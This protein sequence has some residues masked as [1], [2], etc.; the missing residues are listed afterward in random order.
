MSIKRVSAILAILAWVHV[1]ADEMWTRNTFPGEGHV[2]NGFPAGQGQD[3]TEWWTCFTVSPHQYPE[4]MWILMST[5]LGPLM[6]SFDGTADRLASFQVSKLGINGGKQATFDPYLK[7]TAYFLAGNGM[8]RTMDKG[9][10][11]EQIF[12]EPDTDRKMQEAF[13]R[14]SGP[15]EII[16]DPNPARKG[17]LYYAHYRRGL[18]RTKQGHEPDAAQIRGSWE[19]LDFD[20]QMVK[21][22]SAAAM[23]DKTLLYVITVPT[24]VKKRSY[25]VPGEAWLFTIS[26]DGAVEKK[27]VF[28]DLG[29][30]VMCIT[31]HP[32]DP[33]R[34]FV[35]GERNKDERGTFRYSNVSSLGELAL[36]TEDG[37][38]VPRLVAVN[39]SNPD[40]VV[41]SL[42]RKR[43]IP[44]RGF[45]AYS[46]D[47]GQTWGGLKPDLVVKP[48]TD[49]N[50]TYNNAY[51]VDIKH[52]A[53]TNW[54][55]D[56][57]NLGPENRWATD[58]SGGYPWLHPHKR[59]PQSHNLG[60]GETWGSH[61]GT[62][63]RGIMFIPGDQDDVIVFGL[64][65]VREM[66]KS[67]ND[68]GKTLKPHGYGMQFKQPIDVGFGT[69][70]DV[71]AVSR[72]E[73]GVH[74]TQDGGRS[75]R[76]ITHFEDPTLEKAA[77]AARGSFREKSCNSAAFDPDDDNSLLILWGT[78][79]GGRKKT[80]ATVL[81]SNNFGESWKKVH[82]IKGTVDL[83]RYGC[84]STRIVW[85]LNAGGQNRIYA[86]NYRCS[87][88]GTWTFEDI[89]KRFVAV[90]PVDA[91]IVIGTTS[92]TSGNGGQK[93]LI[94]SVSRDAGTTWTELPKIPQELC[95]NRR[96]GKF[97]LKPLAVNFLPRSGRPVSIDPSPQYNPNKN[98]KLR[99][100]L[101]GR[102]G[103]YEYIAA[104]PDGSGGAWRLLNGS[105]F[106]AFP[107]SGQL[108][109]DM[110]GKVEPKSGMTIPSAEV[111]GPKPYLAQIVF[112]KN[113]PQIVYASQ[114]GIKTHMGADE[115]RNPNVSNPS[116]KFPAYSIYRSVDGGK[117]WTLLKGNGLPKYLDPDVINVGPMGTFF[118]E[119]Y[120]GEYR[121]PQ[122]K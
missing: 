83:N 60:R 86:E 122:T 55:G 74:L 118:I 37:Y 70:E 31:I 91:D 67:N 46:S 79:N 9:A 121:L 16:S 10:T 87:N 109:A 100:L 61:S 119:G 21:A 56:N 12:I 95:F 38:E 34:G 5:D 114:G 18:F 58:L 4:G 106:K 64:T 69:S 115:G 92:S 101:A 50:G 68:Y 93:P 7:R 14:P 102:S 43:H 81:Y 98:G 42:D 94:L 23:G 36:P 73:H 35:L 82:S 71:I 105:D 28:E 59:T 17:H 32:K 24:S 19:K 89:G 80:A 30:T 66:L 113:N 45:I 78:P 117:S 96:G 72:A 103:V 107:G 13:S 40:H 97:E 8:F 85:G 57:P 108:S 111:V 62:Q 29:A 26:G 104:N 49:A 44:D 1:N 22:L 6:E 33:T 3:R 99:L 15:H 110:V 76:G 20:G 39:P 53:P 120:S 54:R 47:G 52:Y 27:R 116:E 25:S 65:W 11:W 84:N 112:D 51:N 90:H 48:Y 75:W 88:P 63:S 41:V 2:Q 77:F